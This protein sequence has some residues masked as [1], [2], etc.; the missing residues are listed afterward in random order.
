LIGRRGVLE[1]LAAPEVSLLEVRI[2]R[3]APV[4]LRNEL[5]QRCRSAGV[6]CALT[7]TQRVRALSR[8]ARHDQGVAALARLDNVGGPELLWA[9][10]GPSRWLALDGLRN[11]QN[12]GMIARS[13]VASGMDGLLWPRRGT[14]WVD[15]LVVKA[16]AGAVLRTRIARCEVLRLSLAEARARGYHVAGLCARGENDL[17]SW[18]PPGRAVYVVGSENEGLS[19]DVSTQLDTR[20]RIPI[21]TEVESLNA[22]VAAA[23][24]CFHVANHTRTPTPSR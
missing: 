24:L 17:F 13:A 1:A 22:A 15:G 23:L 9:H 2:A 5:R 12:V 8:D 3:G 7:S 4:A 19:E 20:L 16:S 18:Q 6:A 10:E 14:P 11:A 21:A